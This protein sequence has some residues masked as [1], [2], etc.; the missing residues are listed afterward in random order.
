MSKA[1]CALDARARWAV[2]GTPIQNR[3]GDLAA[4]L[5]F[6]RAHPYDE[7][8]RFDLD[9]GQMW[10][11]GAIEEAALRL[12][13]LSKGLLLRR[14][15]TVIELPPRRD[16]K[17]PVEFNAAERSFYDKLRNK[18]IAKFDD[19]FG[20]GDSRSASNTY[21]TVIQ[22]INALR[23]VCNLGLHYE[24]RH[25]FTSI[26]ES[27]LEDSKEW[28]IG[29]QQA[30]NLQR[31]MGSLNCIVCQAI[32]D[33][34]TAMLESDSQVQAQFSRCLS[35]ICSDCVQKKKR[36]NKP[37][38]CGHSPIHAMAPVS[39]SW[40]AMEES[41]GSTDTTMIQGAAKVA[42]L[43]SKIAALVQQLSSLPGD[44]KW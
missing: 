36:L 37:I 41:L 15:K 7:A 31:E 12:K 16:L 23:L 5:Q 17:F 38:T 4:L 24:S 40:A 2:T 21:I 27:V 14:P 28:S 25:D 43:S 44:V 1:M 29:A 35:F 10:K 3:V 11:A 9:I 6:I 8:R 42:A 22:R 30:F 26:E 32:C 33:M 39:T 13:R 18:V 20:D 34:T 19:I